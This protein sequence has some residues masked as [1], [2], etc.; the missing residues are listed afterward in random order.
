MKHSEMINQLNYLLIR[1]EVTR[2]EIVNKDL[3][4]VD[5]NIANNDVIALTMAIKELKDE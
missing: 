1:L 4:Q 2:D 5:K 3:C